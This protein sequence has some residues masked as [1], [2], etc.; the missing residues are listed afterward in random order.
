MPRFVTPFPSGGVGFRGKSMKLSLVLALAA[1]VAGCGYPSG[2]V[3]NESQAKEAIAVKPDPPPGRSDVPADC[4]LR[5]DFGSYAMGIDG[6]AA[7]AVDDL[8]ARD[9]GVSSVERRPWGREGEMTL[10]VELRSEA[11]AERLFH[12]VA[13]LF[14]ADPRGPLTVSTRSGLR[15]AA[16]RR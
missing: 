7:R 12:A 9:P 11:D 5:V 8:L 2:R 6:G 3:Q 13:A 16:P 4:A 10:C 1:M 14:P 15:F